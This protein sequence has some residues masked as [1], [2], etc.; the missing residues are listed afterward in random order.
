MKSLQLLFQSSIGKKAIMALTGAILLLYV[1]A[2]LAGNLQVFLPRESMNAYAH[3]LHSSPGLL[4]TARIGLL[5]AVGLH[6]WAGI[7]LSSENRA[8][9]TEAYGTDTPPY[10][11]SWASRHMLMTGLVIAAF[12][13]YHLLHLTLQVPAVNLLPAAD[14]AKD[15]GQLQVSSGPQ[16]GYRDVHG[17]LVA[18]FKQP[19]VS[20]FYIIAV[21]LLCIHLRHGTASMFQSLGFEE[22]A[23]RSR[24]DAFA[25]V[26]SILLFL[27]YASIP[28]AIYLRLVQ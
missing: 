13:V 19:V 21:G 20:L 8:A 9:R 24:L 12:V 22:G 4:W 16:Q 11:A 23:W 6:I 1:I 28:I 18:G 26:F 7:A 5:V 27:G 3:L 17:M 14:P 2:H 15:F 25:K 10:A